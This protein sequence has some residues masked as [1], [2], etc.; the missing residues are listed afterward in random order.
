MKRFFTSILLTLGLPLAVAVP[1]AAVSGV[2]PAAA[3]ELL[4]AAAVINDEVISQ[5]DL[6][7]RLKLAIL[8]IGQPD[9]PQ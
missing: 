5:L 7:M 4:R 8:A 9:S 6:D 2:G 3:Q 1:V